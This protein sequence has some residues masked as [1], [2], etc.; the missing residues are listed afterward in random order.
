MVEV[1]VDQVVDVVAVGHRRVTAA[2]AVGVA[3]IVVTAGVSAGAVGRVVRA[4]AQAVLVDVAVGLH[5][6]QVPV[7][8]VVD[9]VLVDH[10]RVAASRAVD[11]IGV[12]GV[13][14][15]VLVPAVVVAGAIIAVATEAEDGAQ[16]H[17]GEVRPEAPPHDATAHRRVAFR[18]WCVVVAGRTMDSER[19]RAAR[20]GSPGGAR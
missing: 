14:V 6:V 10:R 18:P 5:V 17:G 15:G 3:G 16:R 12:V 1:A 11:V 19:G 7:V 13:L 2:A 8:G 9:V 20:V 4:D